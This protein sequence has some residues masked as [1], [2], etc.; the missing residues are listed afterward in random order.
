MPLITIYAA[1]IKADKK[2]AIAREITD[3]ISAS[4]AVPASM[5][6]VYFIPLDQTDAFNAGAPAPASHLGRVAS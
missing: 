3:L 5:I 6:S 1:D 2:K 4:Y